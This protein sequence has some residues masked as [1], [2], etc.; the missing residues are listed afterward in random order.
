MSE[1]TERFEQALT[2][3]ARAHADHR[4]KGTGIPYVAHLLAVASLVLE[5]GGNETE[6]IAALLH[7]AVE[8]GKATL[9]VVRARFGPEVAR[10]VAGCSDTDVFP[11]PPWKERKLS[12]IAHLAAA[13]PSVRLVAAADKLHNARAILSDY[14][15]VGERLW[16]RFNAGKEETLWYYGDLVRV[17]REAGES[18]LVEELARTVEEIRRIVLGPRA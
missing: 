18:P 15:Q 16:G 5:H 11:K 3:A 8:D 6:A 2:F 4:R 14:R 12:Y 13:D 7:D 9:D 10:I 1:L 17:L